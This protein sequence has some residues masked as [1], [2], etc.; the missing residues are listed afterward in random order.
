VKRQWKGLVV[1][2]FSTALVLPAT[3]PLFREAHLLFFFTARFQFHSHATP[4]FGRKGANSPK[5]DWSKALLLLKQGGGRRGQGVASRIRCKIRGQ[6][7]RRFE[8]IEI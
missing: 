2:P 5:K 7:D 1:L 3:T 6:K 4:P 8:R